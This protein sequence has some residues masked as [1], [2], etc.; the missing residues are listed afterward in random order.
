MALNKNKKVP[1]PER[2]IVKYLKF[3]IISRQLS[4][5]NYQYLYANMVY[6]V[7]ALFA[8]NKMHGVEKWGNTIL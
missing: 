6:L 5:D 3:K 8:I 1:L 7:L 2:E 4:A